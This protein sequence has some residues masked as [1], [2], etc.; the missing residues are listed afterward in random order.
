[1]STRAAC[2][3]FSV[4]N[5]LVVLKMVSFIDTTFLIWVCFIACSQLHTVRNRAHRLVL[6]LFSLASGLVSYLLPA[7]AITASENKSVN[8]FRCEERSS[9]S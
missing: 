7:K 3:K 4:L 9:L 2:A 1:M 8:K 5:V 6:C